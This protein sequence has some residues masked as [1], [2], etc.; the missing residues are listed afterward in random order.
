MKEEN[1]KK[2]EDEKKLAEA[3]SNSHEAELRSKKDVSYS[4]VIS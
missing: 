4:S 2:F 3:N 1:T